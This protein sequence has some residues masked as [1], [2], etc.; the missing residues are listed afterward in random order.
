V[1]FSVDLCCKGVNRPTVRG[2]ST[3]KMRLGSLG[4]GGNL[5]SPTAN[6]EST[7]RKGIHI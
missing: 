6:L 4:T 2:K 7:A 3:E 1:G 5:R